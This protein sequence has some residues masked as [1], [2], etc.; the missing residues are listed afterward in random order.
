M[1]QFIL[2]IIISVAVL[3]FMI[4]K[5]KI[6]PVLSLFVGGVVAGTILGMPLADT[7]GTI[8]SGFGSVRSYLRIKM[9]FESRE[10]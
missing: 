4:V 2:A 6:H 8:A 7:V 3:I 5:L 10:L 1:T 9:L